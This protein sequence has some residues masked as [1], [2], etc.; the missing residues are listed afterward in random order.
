MRKNLEL[1]KKMGLSVFY[2]V[3]L[4]FKARMSAKQRYLKK[5][6]NFLIGLKETHPPTSRLLNLLQ[7]RPNGPSVGHAYQEAPR[8]PE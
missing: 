5:L 8:A 7:V 4:G 3:S 6:Q 2:W 1:P